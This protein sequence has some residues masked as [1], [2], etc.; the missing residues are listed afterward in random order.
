MN[1]FNNGV[2]HSPIPNNVGEFHT[3]LLKLYKDPAVIQ[4]LAEQLYD[5][6]GTEN[7][8]KFAYIDDLM[9]FE[10][11]YNIHKIINP[12]DIVII[13]CTLIAKLHSKPEYTYVFGNLYGKID[14]NIYATGYNPEFVHLVSS[15]VTILTFPPSIAG[16]S[17]IKINLHN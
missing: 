16:A 14:T 8:E 5:Y 15:C 17:S 9:S 3:L 7:I 10:V 6:F 12:H 11:D 2:F 13:F 1:N 4:E